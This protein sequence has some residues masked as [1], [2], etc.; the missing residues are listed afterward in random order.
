MTAVGFMTVA[1]TAALFSGFA[2]SLL[3]IVRGAGMDDLMI[4]P[5]FVLLYMA[6]MLIFDI[7]GGFILPQRNGIKP[8][9]TAAVYLKG[10][11]THGVL[12][13][14]S[15]LIIHMGGDLAGM[16]GSILAIIML[17]CMAIAFQYP[18]ACVVGSLR[19]ATAAEDGSS[20]SIHVDSRD[21]S[22]SGSI[23]G[24][25]GNEKILLPRQW[26]T[27]F[28]DSGMSALARRR[29][30]IIKHGWR[31]RGLAL[32]F[33]WVCASWILASLIV[34]FPDST[35]ATTLNTVFCSSIF[36]FLGLLIL[37][38]PTRNMTLLVDRQMKEEPEQSEDFESWVQHFSD[39]TDGEQNRH[40]WIERIFH[41]LPSV[42]SR[43]ANSPSRWA[44]WNATRTM[45]FLSM[46][47]GGLLSRAVHCNVGRPDLWIIAPTD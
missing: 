21:A 6:V 7:A 1:S 31:N 47:T 18:L 41:P 3:N 32:A 37:P 30:L 16:A 13:C 35:V 28:G 39:L 12:L 19:K 20:N 43:L 36:H 2:S 4:F 45:L 15:V 11:F 17:C 29:H 33:I 23:T 24:L 40:P 14:F 10:I 42:Q 22:F 38:T 44:A 9:T 8:H 27:R 25:P 26:K 34:G 46:F 5:G